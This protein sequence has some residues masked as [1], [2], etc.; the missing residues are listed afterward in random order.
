MAIKDS[1]K[2]LLKTTEGIIVF[3]GLTLT[4]LSPI[5]GPK[6]WALITAG[7]YLVVNVPGIWSKIKSWFGS[8][9]DD[10]AADVR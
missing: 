10:D 2:T 3:G 8:G 4:V 6:A 7:A 5:L 1:I 9:G